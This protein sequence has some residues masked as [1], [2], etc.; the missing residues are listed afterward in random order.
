MYLNSHI[1][2]IFN[3]ATVLA[4]SACLAMAVAPVAVHAQE[5]FIGEEA[6]TTVGV[7]NPNDQSTRSVSSEMTLDEYW[8]LD[9][10]SRATPVDA[11][12]DLP[13]AADQATSNS[14][15]VVVSPEAPE[16]EQ[17]ASEPIEPFSSSQTAGEAHSRIGNSGAANGK[18]FFSR[19]VNGQYEDRVCSA[20]AVNSDNKSTVITAGHC[21]H[22]GSGGEFHKNWVFVP[23]YTIGVAPHGRFKANFMTTTTDWANYG[24][25]PRG[26]AADFGFVTVNSERGKR[27]VD[28]VGGHGL[29]S[30]NAGSFKA[31]IIGYPRNRFLGSAMFRCTVPVKNENSSSFN[32]YM[33]YGCNFGGGASGG[34]WLEDF[35]G[36][37][38]HIRSVSS[39]GPENGASYL[40]SPIITSKI[41]DMFDSTASRPVK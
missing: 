19:K 11:T 18:V 15:E 5:S 41:W 6:E 36:T 9:R 3:R 13:F 37:L 32:F 14:K 12:L 27:L 33:S 8:T 38:G 7:I 20:S 29:R 22:S 21:V 40:G 31:D 2:K 30:G 1:R 28:S 39:F 25:T 23:E 10:M 35:N 24:T 16:R 17:E 4:S 26:F 34:A